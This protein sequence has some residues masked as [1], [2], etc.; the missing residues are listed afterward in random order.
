MSKSL[1]GVL[2]KKAN[3]R[4]TFTEEQINDLMQC[5]NPDTGYL[6]FAEKFAY[7]Q[8]PVRG[9]T[10]YRKCVYRKCT[11]RV[12]KKCHWLVLIDYP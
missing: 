8:H 11:V 3:Q 2:T 7:I 4:E 12:G 6:Y 10:M 5:M 9:K 1:D